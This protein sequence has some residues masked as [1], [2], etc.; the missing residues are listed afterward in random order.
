MYDRILNVFF[1]NA[2]GFITYLRNTSF[3]MASAYGLKFCKLFFVWEFESENLSDVI[4]VKSGRLQKKH[5]Q[6]LEF[7]LMFY[8]KFSVVLKSKFQS[9]RRISES[10]L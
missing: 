8:F 10:A 6:V 9:V 4:C 1:Q 7:E 3:P 2:I 5:G